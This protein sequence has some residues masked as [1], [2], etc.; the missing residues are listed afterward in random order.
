MKLFVEGLLAGAGA[1]V[2]AQGVFKY[3]LTTSILWLIGWGEA[4]AKAVVKKTIA[5]FKIDVSK[6]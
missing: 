3:N 6:L 1:V 2:V 4:H 5:T